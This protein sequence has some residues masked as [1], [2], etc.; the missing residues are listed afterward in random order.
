MKRLG[1]ALAFCALLCG[2]ALAQVGMPFPGPG[3]PVA[4]PTCSQATTFLARTSGLSTPE[5]NAVTTTI[6]Q[7][8]SNGIITGTLSGAA[9]CGTVLQGFYFTVTNNT[10]TANLNICGTSFGLTST[11]APTFTADAGYVGNGTTQFLNT[12]FTP[13]TSG[14]AVTTTS[15]SI[16]VYIGNTRAASGTATDIGAANVA[17]SSYTYM[18]ALSDS[19]GVNGEVNGFTFPPSWSTAATPAGCT[20]LSRIGTTINAYKNSSGTGLSPIATGDTA[21]ALPDNP[22]FLLA[23]DGP[24]ASTPSSFAPDTL[25]AAYYGAGITGAQHVAI[26]NAINAGLA[27]FGLNKF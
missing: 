3:G 24:T 11:A 7:L 16:G 4:P 9:G 8:V 26:C 25:Y 17:N 5:T 1:L 6:C 12:N 15:N 19:T 13:S 27:V 20:S 18:N 21:L 23:F 2:S 22:Y 14:V 10:T